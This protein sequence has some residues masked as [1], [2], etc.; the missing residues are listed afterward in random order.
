MVFRQLLTLA[1]CLAVASATYRPGY[2]EEY[3]VPAV[4]GFTA[5]H[6]A[7]SPQRF[8]QRPD[9]REISVCK[10]SD[11]SINFEVRSFGVSQ[12]STRTIVLR[13]RRSIIGRSI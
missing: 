4:P 5:A 7:A 12:T 3:P 6:A 13:E 9:N 11:V 1:L 8:Q 10:C 2:F